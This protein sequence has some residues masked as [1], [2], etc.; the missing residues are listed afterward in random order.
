M[1]GLNSAIQ[2]CTSTCNIHFYESPCDLFLYP[3][4]LNKISLFNPKRTIFSVDPNLHYKSNFV[5]FRIYDSFF[6]NYR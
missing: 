3:L 5:H 1:V 2:I 4:L 6:P